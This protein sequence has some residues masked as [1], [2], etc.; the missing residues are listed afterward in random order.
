[1]FKTD[2]NKSE[3]FANL[4]KL[5]Y[6]TSLLIPTDLKDYK[7]ANKNSSNISGDFYINPIQFEEHTP[8]LLVLQSKN[9]Y[10]FPLLSDFNET[11][12]SF[13]NFKQRLNL[14][15]LY[16]TVSLGVDI[17]T[18]FPQSYTSVLN[19]FRSDYEDFG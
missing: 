18:T 6:N 2:D 16:N 7:L 15:S 9:F 3:K 10:Q 17:K 8:N 13:N 4:E 12:D 1:L 14:N 11:D 19:N 5:F